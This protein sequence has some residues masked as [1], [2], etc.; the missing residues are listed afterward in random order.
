MESEILLQV[1]NAC[2]VYSGERLFNPVTF[3][4]KS[5]E[6]IALI[7]P[8]GGGKST[9]LKM[10]MG[11]LPTD[12]GLIIKKKNLSIGYLSQAVISGKDQT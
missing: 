11:D 10:I 7:G 1:Q 5:G 9:I 12:E 8:N 3:E 4:V 2:K 6:R